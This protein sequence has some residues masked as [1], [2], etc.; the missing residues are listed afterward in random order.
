MMMFC[1]RTVYRTYTSSNYL[2]CFL[3]DENDIDSFKSVY[4]E[5]QDWLKGPVLGTGAF[6]T[7]YQARDAQ[8][9]TIMAMKQVSAMFIEMARRVIYNLVNPEF[10]LT[11]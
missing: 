6:S 3:Q 7:C 10:L 8:T 1:L 5:D 11:N 9:G 2:N 4:R